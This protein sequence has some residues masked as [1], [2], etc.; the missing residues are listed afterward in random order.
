[1]GVTITLTTIRSDGN[2]A[3]AVVPQGAALGG[4]YTLV[5]DQNGCRATLNG[6]YTTLPPSGSITIA[7]VTPAYGWTGQDTPV[8]I[9]GSGFVS[10]PSAYIKVPGMTPAWRRLK[11]VAFTSS[12]SL[13]AVV[14]KGL[15]PTPAGPKYSVA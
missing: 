14:P 9:V 2:V 13:T 15:T 6:A 12:S 3:T 11:N 8:T 10:T 5:D 7:S 1:G 4:P